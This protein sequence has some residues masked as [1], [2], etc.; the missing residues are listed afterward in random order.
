MYD[1]DEELQS[2]NET[3]KWL[4][5]TYYYKNNSNLSHKDKCLHNDEDYA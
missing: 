1:V 4:T 5:E 2:E 3:T